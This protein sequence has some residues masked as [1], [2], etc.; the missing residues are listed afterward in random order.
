MNI[1][2]L[3]MFSSKI[4]HSLEIV[5]CE[6]NVYNYF[7]N[8]VIKK[9]T[10]KSWKCNGQKVWKL[11][12]CSVW[13]WPL[14]TKPI[15]DVDPCIYVSHISVLDIWNDSTVWS[16]RTLHVSQWWQE[17][18]FY[19]EIGL[20]IEVHYISPAVADNEQWLAP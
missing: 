6:C 17:V 8:S 3:V 1:S 19:E 13:I 12:E 7:K 14:K 16:E 18:T 15:L 11:C 5:L 9:N 4:F 20:I 2:L 10:E